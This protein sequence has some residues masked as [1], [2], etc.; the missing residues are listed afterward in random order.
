M[1]QLSGSSGGALRTS[2]PSHWGRIAVPTK[3]LPAYLGSGRTGTTEWLSGAGGEERFAEAQIADARI[4]VARRFSGSATSGSSL[5]L[6]HAPHWDIVIDGSVLDI[7]WSGSD[8]S[9]GVEETAVQEALGWLARTTGLSLV[10]LA[11]L[12][13]VTR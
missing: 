1:M 4:S 10:R 8:A 5:W 6:Q 7:S 11:R 9:P 2:T 12:L 13:G 3:G